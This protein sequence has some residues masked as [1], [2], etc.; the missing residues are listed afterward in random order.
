[1]FTN[2]P[3]LLAESQELLP[4]G[5]LGG[6]P[7]ELF[8]YSA[9]KQEQSTRIALRETALYANLGIAATMLTI[10]FES[11]V[12][13]ASGVLLLAPLVSGVMFW[14]Y[15]NN[16]Y[17][18]SAIGRYVTDYLAPRLLARFSSA[19]GAPK[20]SRPDL[21]FAWERAHKHHSPGWWARR[22]VARI[23][24][25]FSFLTAPAAALVYTFPKIPSGGVIPWEWGVDLLVSFLVLVGI[26]RLS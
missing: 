11:T 18:V 23:V 17:Y 6:Q 24:L 22:A 15:Y 26:F 3:R 7:I 4:A 19:E 5:D 25:L 16:D 9:L 12:V 1:M 20:T 21:L 8:E 2:L 10:H 13:L 14:I